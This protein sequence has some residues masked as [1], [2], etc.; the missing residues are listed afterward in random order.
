MIRFFESAMTTSAQALKEDQKLVAGT[1]LAK[2]FI[3][4]TNMDS[5]ENLT[6]VKKKVGIQMS[7]TQDRNL[8]LV[9]I[10]LKD[11]KK[12]NGKFILDSKDKR[13]WVFHTLEKSDLSKR[14]IH[15]LVG[16]SLSKLDNIWL[17]RDFLVDFTKNQPMSE[18]SAGF[19]TDI[20]ASLLDQDYISKMSIRIWGT[21]SRR[22]LNTLRESQLRNTIALRAVR[23]RFLA[24]EE[25]TQIYADERMSSKG[26]L[27][28]SGTSATIHIQTVSNVINQYDRIISDI[29]ESVEDAKSIRDV[30]PQYLKFQ[31]RKTDIKRFVEL[32]YANMHHLRIFGIPSKISS[33]YYRIPAVDLHNGDKLDLEIFPEGIRVTLWPKACGNTIL[34][35]ENR[36]QKYVDADVVRSVD[37]ES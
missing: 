19:E 4:E 3:I 10:S 21:A 8:Y 34:R 12:N 30:I 2:S 11:K 13:Y 26:V 7:D 9:T 16:T 18:F 32:V 36:L 5:P 27:S 29:E 15:H 22:A 24:D 37:D 35:L 23:A 6:D 33:K 17:S 14:L 1:N 31:R 20:P 25:E 28:A